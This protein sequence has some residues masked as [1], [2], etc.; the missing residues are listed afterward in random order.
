MIS[1]KKI[2]NLSPKETLIIFVIFLTIINLIYCIIYK[3]IA[4]HLIDNEGNYIITNI[5]FVFGRSISSLIQENN[6]SLSF[7]DFLKTWGLTTNINM[8]LNISRRPLLPLLYIFIA[9]FITSNFTLFH[10]VKNLFFGM[11][12]FFSI[13]S[14]KKNYNIL[15]VIFSLILIYYNPHNTFTMLSTN[16]EEGI[17]NYL[18]ILL[19]LILIIEVKFK[20]IYLSIILISIFFL[21]GSMFLLVFAIALFYFFY[22]K[23]RKF[24]FLLI[25]S[26]LLSNIFWGYINFD[27]TG[28]FAIGLKGSSMNAINMTMVTNKIFNKIYPKILPDIL[29]VR[30]V[31]IIESK[32]I[33]SEKELIDYLTERSIDYIKKNPFEYFKGVLKKI[34][35]LNISPFK[36]A[37][38][39]GSKVYDGFGLKKTSQDIDYKTYLL[40][41]ENGREDLNPKI[42]NPIRYSNFPNKIIF[43]ISIFLML[44]TFFN[45]KKSFLNKLNIYYFVILLTYLAPYM[46]GWLYQRHATAVYILAHLYCFFYLVEKKESINDLLKK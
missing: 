46:Y 27:K 45:K 1:F 40:N 42:I 8:E 15:F 19:F 34:Y 3:K 23:K 4:P 43:N 29:M 31:E 12:I 32:N 33:K 35:V 39:P 9:K 16:F 5:G 21:K 11:L 14:L 20:E 36:D 7:N 17:L 38:V 18:I 28:F 10:L 22:E 44:L 24:R 13:N 2:E 25:L 26:V 41:I 37:V 6:L 30:V